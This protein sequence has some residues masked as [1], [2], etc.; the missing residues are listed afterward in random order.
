MA[1]VADQFQ[2]TYYMHLIYAYSKCLGLCELAKNA[3]LSTFV[4]NL[5][6]VLLILLLLI[7]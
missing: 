5:F 2:F 7:Y 6:L 1:H 4:L 3:D